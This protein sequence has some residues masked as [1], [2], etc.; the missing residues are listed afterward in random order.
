MRARA[1]QLVLQD[2]G[3]LRF[4][5]G[6]CAQPRRLLWLAAAGSDGLAL[7]PSASA[8]AVAPLE[9]QC[10]DA[11]L[12]HKFDDALEAGVCTG[13]TMADARGRG[14]TPLLISPTLP[15]GPAFTSTLVTT[16]RSTGGEA[17]S[18]GRSPRH[19]ISS[20]ALNGAAES[21]HSLLRQ[22]GVRHA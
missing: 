11:A 14:W 17:A 10:P 1:S 21:T 3:G 13:W 22:A 12:A 16:S 7:R 8:P 19:P 2:V 9:A 6:P 15:R 18:E 4:G 20:A 5:D